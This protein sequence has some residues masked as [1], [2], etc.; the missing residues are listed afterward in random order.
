MYRI[1]PDPET[2]EQ[3]A[4]L[5]AEA[6]ADYA[7]VLTVLEVQPWAGQPQHTANPDGAVRY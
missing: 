6:L 4:A 3:V 1:I 5:P 2:F 7:E